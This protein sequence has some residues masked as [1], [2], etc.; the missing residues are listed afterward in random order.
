[1]PVDEVNSGIVSF[2]SVAAMECHNLAINFCLTILSI[3]DFVSTNILIEQA[4]L[5][6]NYG[7]RQVALIYIAITAVLR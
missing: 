3:K 1:M 4:S 2:S 6:H 5:K 7:I